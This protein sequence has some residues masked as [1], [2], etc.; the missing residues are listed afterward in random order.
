MI[1]INKKL[2]TRC[3]LLAS[4]LAMNS[5][6]S[7]AKES[8]GVQYEAR[9]INAVDQ[10]EQ[11]Q[12]DQALDIVDGL[13]ADYPKSRV[14]ALIKA[15]ILS[16]M[17]GNLPSFG[18]GLKDDLKRKNFHH[19]LSLRSTWKGAVGR[20]DKEAM[21]PASI[22]DMGQDKFVFVGE[23]E[24][25]RFFIFGN[26]KGK[27]YLVKDFY[28][29]IGSAGS[30]KQI[31]GDNKTP[32]GLYSV[33]REIAGNKLPDLYG[34]G[35]FPVDYPNKVDKWRKRTGYGIWLHGTPSDTYS[36]V[37]LASEGCFVLSNEDYE[38][39][40][41]YMRQVEKPRVLLLDKINWL[42]QEQHQQQR[43]DY[44]KVMQ[45]WVESWESLDMDRYSAFYDKENLNFGKLDYNTWYDRK[46]TVNER[47]KFIQLS[48]GLQSM[49]VY[50]GEKDMFAVDFK[51]NYLSDNYQGVS[52]KTIYWKKSSNGQWKII[53]EGDRV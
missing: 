12:L 19:E 3:L 23:A 13:L 26:D 53:Y 6:L 9:L 33:T 10:I 44:L 41:V 18:S 48:L 40:A 38:E 49:Y 20:V 2:N 5:S 36:R 43:K 32:V 24:T 11:G 34:S 15:D 7:L 29:T 17:S 45:E 35:A 46:K 52:D 16:A 28:M 8:S 27:P 31:E 25:G 51:Q 14:S 4:F 22:L 39:V 50:P 30:G 1:T 37:P 47:K 42:T 21:I